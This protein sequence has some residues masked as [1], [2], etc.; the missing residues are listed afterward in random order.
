M[1]HGHLCPGAVMLRLPGSACDPGEATDNLLWSGVHAVLCD[2][3][4]AEGTGELS[5][6]VGGGG[7]FGFWGMI[8]AL[9]VCMYVCITPY[10]CTWTKRICVCMCIAPEQMACVM[11]RDGWGWEGENAWMDPDSRVYWDGPQAPD[12]IVVLRP[13]QGVMLHL[14]ITDDERRTKCIG[15]SGVAVEDAVTAATFAFLRMLPGRSQHSRFALVY[16]CAALVHDERC[17]LV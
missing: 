10:V 17:L 7:V 15:A 1:I 3:Q 14:P 6:E 16:M 12:S 5:E 9:Y 4:G 8:C 11:D 13:G 2:W